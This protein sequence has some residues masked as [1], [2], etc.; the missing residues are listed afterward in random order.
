MVNKR[1]AKRVKVTLELTVS[2][3]FDQDNDK[4]NIDSPIMVKDIS[5]FGLG[6]ISKSILPINYYFNAALKLG[7]EESTLYCV[8]KIIR[9]EA[10]EDDEYSYGCEFV[11]LAPVL[12]YIFEDLE[13]KS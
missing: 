3:L 8:V 6:F 9:C 2:S 11:G 10:L 4:I 5:K 12:D 7:S 13:N 1:R